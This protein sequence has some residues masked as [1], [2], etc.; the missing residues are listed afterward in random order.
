[1]N[2][3]KEM[4]FDLLNNKDKKSPFEN[5]AR[6]LN[7][8]ISNKDN[9]NPKTL[10]K[11]NNE[12][13][14]LKNKIKTENINNILVNTTPKKYFEDKYFNSIYSPLSEYPYL[15]SNPFKLGNNNRQSPENFRL[16]SP[17]NNSIISNNNFFYIK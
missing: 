16:N 9:E 6:S 10:I 2:N 5:N 8:Q 3:R 14:N 1:M 17:M 4:N 15:D 11:Q 13:E 7:S 12:F